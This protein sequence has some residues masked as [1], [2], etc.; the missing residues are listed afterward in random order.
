MSHNPAILI[1]YVL[2]AGFVID[3]AYLFY[4]AYIKD[5]HKW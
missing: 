4:R 1:I 3:V 2:C 5:R